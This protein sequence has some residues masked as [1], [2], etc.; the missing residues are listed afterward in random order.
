MDKELLNVLKLVDIS[1]YVN[2]KN[3]N[4]NKYFNIIS[5]GGGGGF[6][7]NDMQIYA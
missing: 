3:N 1:R 4:D 6:L 5:V 7:L 2:Q